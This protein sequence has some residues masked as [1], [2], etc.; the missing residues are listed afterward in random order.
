MTRNAMHCNTGDVPRGE[1]GIQTVQ[2][3]SEEG[4]A[5]PPEHRRESGGGGH[6][7]HRPTWRVP[8]GVRTQVPRSG[9]GCQCKAPFPVP[10]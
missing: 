3:E 10:L 6:Q 9:R 2:V 4:A 8:R 7:L 5:S 1:V